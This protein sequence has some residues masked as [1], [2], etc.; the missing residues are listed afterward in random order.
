MPYIVMNHHSLE[1]FQTRSFHRFTNLYLR[2]TE[3]ETDDD[4]VVLSVARWCEN[5]AD[6]QQFLNESV[7]WGELYRIWGFDFARR[8]FMVVSAHVELVEGANRKRDR[9]EVRVAR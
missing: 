8:N 1:G 7:A 3:T 5:I 2:D 6:A 9:Y 4:G